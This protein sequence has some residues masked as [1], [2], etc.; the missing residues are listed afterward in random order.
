MPG[1]DIHAG[2]NLALEKFGIVSTHNCGVSAGAAIGAMDS[3]GHSAQTI[4]FII[5]E[6]S[7]EDVRQERPFWKLRALVIDW[8]LDNDKIWNLLTRVLP[9][10]DFY[11]LQKP[12]R[13]WATHCETGGERIFEDGTRTT[14]QLQKALLASM[15]IKGI[16]PSVEIYDELYSDGGTNSN[17]PLPED[18]LEYDEVWF[19]IATPPTEFPDRDGII[20]NLLLNV[21]WLM[22]A[23]IQRTLEFAR[24]LID[25][26]IPFWRPATKI[27]VIRPT[28]GRESSM[29]RFDHSL[30]DQAQAEAIS[31]ISQQLGTRFETTG[32]LTAD[33]ANNTDGHGSESIKTE[34]Q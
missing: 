12:L 4:A 6:L 28:C 2:I 8:F 3:C 25:L 7:D 26:G 23:Q 32:F 31:Q 29:L 17:L 34:V 27:F 24:S 13:V 30:I 14:P 9:V 1:L 15:A 33:H 5:R 18:F 20:S 21:A 19:L 16:F 22:E 10:S 11:Q